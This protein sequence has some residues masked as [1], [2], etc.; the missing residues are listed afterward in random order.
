[1]LLRLHLRMDPYWSERI[2]LDDAGRSRFDCRG[3]AFH[4]LHETARKPLVHLLTYLLRVLT[5]FTSMHCE[6][7][8]W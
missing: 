3:I 5:L 8:F 4:S 6:W 1:M 2:S 7:N